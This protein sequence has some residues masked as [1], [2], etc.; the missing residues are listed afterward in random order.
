[1]RRKS[2][3]YPLRLVVEHF[4]QLPDFPLL[5]G[6]R[7]ECGHIVVQKRDMIGPTNAYRRRCGK[8][9]REAT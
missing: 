5:R 2:D 6:E 3:A 8:C 1:M 9:A 7:L 4:V